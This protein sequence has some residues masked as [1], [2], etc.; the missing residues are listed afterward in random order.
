MRSASNANFD[1]SILLADGGPPKPN[2]DHRDD[3][4]DM[5]LR[6]LDVEWIDRLSMS[7]R[8]VRLNETYLL[9]DGEDSARK[10]SS[11]TSIGPTEMLR[12][13]KRVRR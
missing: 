4:P 5:T 3:M 1:F 11:R 8:D 6:T 7:W 10:L 2:E 9:V 13:E 12:L